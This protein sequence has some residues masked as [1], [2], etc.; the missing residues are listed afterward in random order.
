MN[1]DVRD[2][3]EL[4]QVM[5]EHADV[6]DQK[7]ADCDEKVPAAHQLPCPLIHEGV[8]SFTALLRNGFSI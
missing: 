3:G 8:V 6:E 1:G 4:T 5:L 7:H 2:V